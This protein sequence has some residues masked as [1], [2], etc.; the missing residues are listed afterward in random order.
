MTVYRSTDD[1]HVLHR[2][3]HRE[4]VITNRIGGHRQPE[5]SGAPA[6]IMSNPRAIGA[7]R[8]EPHERVGRRRHQHSAFRQA[9][10]AVV[11]AHRRTGGNRLPETNRRRITGPQTV[12][13]TSPKLAQHPIPN[14]ARSKT[15]PKLVTQ[16]LALSRM[17]FV[18]PQ[19]GNRGV[20]DGDCQASRDRNRGG[21]LAAHSKSCGSASGWAPHHQFVHGAE[22]RLKPTVRVGTADGPRFA[23]AVADR[24]GRKDL[25]LAV[26]SDSPRRT[27]AEIDTNNRQFRLQ[28]RRPRARGTR[29]CGWL[30]A[31]RRPPFRGCSGRL[32]TGRG[33]R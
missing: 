28:Y 3:R 33:H 6:G 27:A 25:S 13:G 16:N 1:R 32:P 22:H 31:G 5:P 10:T 17:N 15:I 4:H 11:D 19:V 20:A 24:S 7:A 18:K 21:G 23:T 9:M 26:T 2:A 30:V 14:L 12:K 29:V 8:P